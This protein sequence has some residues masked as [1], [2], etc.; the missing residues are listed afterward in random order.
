MASRLS[1]ISPLLNWSFT[2]TD[3]VVSIQSLYQKSLWMYIHRLKAVSRLHRLKNFHWRIIVFRQSLL[4][5]HSYVHLKHVNRLSRRR[6]AQ[7]W[8]PTASQVGI[9]CRKGMRTFSGG[10]RNVQGLLNLTAW[11]CGRCRVV[12][13]EVYNICWA[14]SPRFVRLIVVSIFR[15]SSCYRQRLVLFLHP[16]LRNN[17]TLV[18]IRVHFGC[19]A[20]M[21]KRMLKPTYWRNSKNVRITSTK[22]KCGPWNDQWNLLYF[23]NKQY[24]K[25]ITDD[26][27]LYRITP[28]QMAHS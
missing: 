17:P 12:S 7:I 20:R 13:V 2:V 6:K 4:T 23:Y 18:N 9:Q 26:L 8:Y 28:V 24:L 10:L 15:I 25:W 16:R 3:R 14:N 21:I 1:V 5:F 19:S 27:N 22:V 11:L